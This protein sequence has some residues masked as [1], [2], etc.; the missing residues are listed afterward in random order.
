MARARIR[1]HLDG[2]LMRLLALALVLVFG[3]RSLG[4]ACCSGVELVTSVAQASA[5]DDDCCPNQAGGDAAGDEG[6]DAPCPCPARCPA[7]CTG[8]PGRTLLPYLALDLSAP[9]A[10]L[11][12][13]FHRDATRPENPDPTDI[14]HVPKPAQV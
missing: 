2:A 13:P 4:G 8:Q 7:G 14:L 12:A 11:D 9:A 6:D 5:P 1:R 3:G 10:V